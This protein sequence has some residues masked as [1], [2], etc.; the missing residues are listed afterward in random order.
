MS[1]LVDFLDAPANSHAKESILMNKLFLDVK[2][3]AARRGYYL[4]TYF[5]TVDHDGFDVIFDDQDV[6]IKTQLKSVR[7]DAKTRKWNIKKKVLRPSLQD[8]EC[9]GFEF[10]PLGVGVGGGALL[11]KYGESSGE[12]V[13]EYYYTDAYI[14]SAFQYDVIRRKHASSNKAIQECL[15]GLRQGVGATFLTV[16]IS[17]FLK[18]KDADRL[19]ALMCLHGPVSSFWSSNLVRLISYEC[20]YEKEENLPAPPEKLRK[21]IWEEISDLVNEP[22]LTQ[23]DYE[24]S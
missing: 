8:S 21:Y 11:M 2:T 9:L 23:G 5:D 22:R 13:A 20:G 6:L 17:A 24:R 1:S 18:A 10:S 3:S 4:N 7:S 16:P 12:I 15:K 14:L 19:L